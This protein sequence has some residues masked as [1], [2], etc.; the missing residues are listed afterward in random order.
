M[1]LTI[2]SGYIALVSTVLVEC[3]LFASVIICDRYGPSMEDASNHSVTLLV[4]RSIRVI[5]V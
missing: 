3:V 5:D 1:V 4:V 2:V